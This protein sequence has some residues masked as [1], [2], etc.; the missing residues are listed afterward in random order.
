MDFMLVNGHVSWN[1]SAKLKEIFRTTIDNSTWRMY[2]AKLMLNWKDP[3][4]ECETT[5]LSPVDT[6]NHCLKPVSKSANIHIWCVVCSL[7]TSIPTSLGIQIVDICDQ[8]SNHIATCTN[9]NCDIIARSQVS[10]TQKIFSSRFH[11]LL[12]CLVSKLL[13]MNYLWDSSL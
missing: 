9:P 2:V 8:S 1:M 13:I 3:M 5:I 6:D 10:S 4:V 11:N 12:G 7:E